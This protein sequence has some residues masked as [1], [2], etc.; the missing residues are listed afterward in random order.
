[1]CNWGSWS[2]PITNQSDCESQAGVAIEGNTICHFK[3]PKNKAEC[4]EVKT[5]EDESPESGD[6]KLVY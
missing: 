6:K 4:E 1:M 5:D 3:T 2:S